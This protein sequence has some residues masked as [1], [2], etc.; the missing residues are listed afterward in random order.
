[1]SS[2]VIEVQGQVIEARPAANFL[3]KLDSGQE[4]NAHL[5][6]KIRMHYIKIIPGDRVIVQ[7]SPYD[8]T[9]GR[10]VRRLDKGVFRQNQEN[11]PGPRINQPELKGAD[12][13]KDESQ[14]IG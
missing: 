11:F 6:G 8:L 9:R 10:I 1:M 4:V 14:T 5:S 7:M 12:K 13:D 2:E 3:V